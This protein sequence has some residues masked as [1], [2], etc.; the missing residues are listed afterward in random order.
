[1]VK[2]KNKNKTDVKNKMYVVYSLKG[3]DWKRNLFL[4]FVT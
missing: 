4:I 2:I 3:P 1:M